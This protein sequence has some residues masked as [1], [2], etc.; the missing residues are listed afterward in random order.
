MIAA[1]EL[2]PLV[3]GALV[4]TLLG[5][6]D[7]AY[8]RC[9][10]GLWVFCLLATMMLLPAYS[11]C[12]AALGF[13]LMIL[14]DFTGGDLLGISIVGLLLGVIPL[15]LVLA[16]GFAFTLGTLQARVLWPAPW[17]TVITL[18]AVAAFLIKELWV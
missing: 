15:C 4:L 3:G 1:V 14:A 5:L 16:L 9:P 7:L 6:W 17:L 10:V 11:L 8:R 18:P 12:G 13:V 2:A